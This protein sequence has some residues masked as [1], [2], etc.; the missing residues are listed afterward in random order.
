MTILLWMCSIW[1]KMGMVYQTPALLSMCKYSSGRVLLTRL[2]MVEVNVIEN[3]DIVDL[4]AKCEGLKVGER[5]ASL[6]E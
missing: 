4:R 2:V 6:T 5:R 3:G 1:N